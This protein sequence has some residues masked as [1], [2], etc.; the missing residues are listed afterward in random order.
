VTLTAFWHPREGVGMTALPFLIRP[1]AELPGLCQFPGCRHVIG[2]TNNSGAATWCAEHASLRGTSARDP[3]VPRTCAAPGCPEPARMRTSARG[4][5]PGLCARHLRDSQRRAARNWGQRQEATACERTADPTRRAFLPRQG[6][7]D[8]R[9][10]GELVAD[11][12]QVLVGLEGAANAKAPDP[13][14]WGRR[15]RAA[16][17]ALGAVVEA[18]RRFE[19]LYCNREQAGCGNAASGESPLAAQDGG[20]SHAHRQTAAA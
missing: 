20:H 11:Y 13:A 1:L 17:A 18:W 2:A 5:A 3:D 7:L 4:R 6:R 9:Q 14:L 12:D 19:S 8:L 10:L 16:D 15:R